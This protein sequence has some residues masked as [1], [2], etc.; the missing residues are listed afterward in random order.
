MISQC[1]R[2]NIIKYYWNVLTDEPQSAPCHL[3]TLLAGFD[4]PDV[5]EGGEVGYFFFII[6]TLKVITQNR[7]NVEVESK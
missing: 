7:S 5:G 6:F 3:Q 4:P 1:V 2:V